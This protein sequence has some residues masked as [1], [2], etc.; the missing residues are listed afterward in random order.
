MKQ[1]NFSGVWIPGGLGNYNIF[2][3]DG[4]Q[5]G[6]SIC[7]NDDWAKGVT[8]NFQMDRNGGVKIY[9]GG[10]DSLVHEL[11]VP[12]QSKFYNIPNSCV[13]N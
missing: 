6:L 10:N 3:G 8:S 2:A 9:F 11:A 5:V 13:G 4:E 1:I 12:F 7:Y